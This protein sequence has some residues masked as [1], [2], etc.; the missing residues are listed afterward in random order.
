M[1]SKRDSANSLRSLAKGTNKNFFGRLE[2]N[3]LPGI[4]KCIG[5][6]NGGNFIVNVAKGNEIMMH[7]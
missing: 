6:C 4:K 5:K 7:I 2:S 3:D 1:Y